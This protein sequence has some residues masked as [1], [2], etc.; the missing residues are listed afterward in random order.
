MTLRCALQIEDFSEAAT[1][2]QYTHNTYFA[3][4]KDR[5]AMRPFQGNADS[6]WFK[7]SPSTVIFRNIDGDEQEKD[8]LLMSEL[9]FRLKVGALPGTTLIPCLCPPEMRLGKST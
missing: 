4:V 7:K 1:E 2:L 5:N 9:N 3:I 8:M 6:L